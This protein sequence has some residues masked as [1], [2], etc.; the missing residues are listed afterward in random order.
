MN[1]RKLREIL[2]SKPPELSGEAALRIETRIRERME[3]GHRR[4]GRAWAMAIAP[5]M[6]IILALFWLLP[7]GGNTPEFFLVNED[8]FVEYLSQME[9]TGGDLTEVLQLEYELDGDDWSNEQ[10]ETFMN[11]LENFS[12]DTI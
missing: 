5:A 1:D 7:R 9:N 12:L 6:L 4:P 8:Q 3:A 2:E 11:E 10:R